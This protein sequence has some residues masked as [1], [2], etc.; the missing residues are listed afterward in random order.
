MQAPQRRHPLQ[1]LNEA[2]GTGLQGL[3][4]IQQQREQQKQLE[5]QKQSIASMLG[6]EAVNLPPEMQKVF[7]AEMMKN[8]GKVN[9]QNLRS[10]QFS[11]M[12]NKNRPDAQSQGNRLNSSVENPEMQEEQS[13]NGIGLDQVND[14]SNWDDMDILG[15]GDPQMIAAAQRAKD[16]AVREKRETEKAQRRR[17]ES[18][19]T[20]EENLKK[21]ARKEELGFHNESA[22]YDEELFKQAK[23]AKKQIEIIKES[24]K[25]INSGKVKPSSLAN[26]F[27]GLGPI[28]DKLSSALLNKDE[29]V[30]LS[31]IPEFLEGRKELFGVRLSDA[32]LRLLQDK[33]PD[34]GKSP[35]S[36]KAILGIMRKYAEA[37]QI[38]YKL[39]KDIKKKNKDLRPLGYAEKVEERYDE[40]MSPV[41]I[42][43]PNTGNVIEIPTY[44]LG[45]AI[46]A[47]ATLYNE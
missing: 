39:A 8:Q 29:A 27:K 45:D 19:R 6:P 34:I 14:P 37:S 38:R 3:G 30:I 40:M 25:A 28:G 41:K 4:Q 35:E 26:M 32:D 31:A 7:L 12:V 18:D 10:Q 16:V 44:E 24:E 46:E 13:E 22:K 36:N 1:G 47:G 5:Q 15:L 11:N 23:V 33:L 17:F 21:E 2:V 43:N 20:Y 42:I 9:L